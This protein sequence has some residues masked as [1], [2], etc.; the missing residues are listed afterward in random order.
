MMPPGGFQGSALALPRPLLDF[1]TG[2]M[3]PP[4]PLGGSR[5]ARETVF[6]QVS[7]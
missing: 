4:G 5:G 6:F 3:V 1:P 2:G 7:Q